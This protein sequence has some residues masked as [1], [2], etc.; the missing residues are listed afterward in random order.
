MIVGPAQAAWSACAWWEYRRSNPQARE[1][2]EHVAVQLLR[3]LYERARGAALR[4]PRARAGHPGAP[5]PAG[6]SRARSCDPAWPRLAIVEAMDSSPAER[7]AQLRTFH[8]SRY[9]PQQLAAARAQRALRVSV[10]LPARECA[11]TVAEIVA[12]LDALR[13]QG[14]ARRDRRRRRGVERR[15]GPGRQGRRRGRPAGVRADGVARAGARQGRRDVASAAGAQRRHRVLSG[16]R[17][18]GLPE[19]LR[20]GAARPAALRARRVVR[21]RPSTGARCSRATSCCQTAAGG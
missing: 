6:R 20:H 4:A 1:R 9:A 10:C 7:A 3:G 13:A 14:V 15:H 11:A 19:P 18:R 17:H 12:T 5:R 16:C 21:A 8:H 2:R